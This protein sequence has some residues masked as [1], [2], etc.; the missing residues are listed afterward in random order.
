MCAFMGSGLSGPVFGILVLVAAGV[1]LCLRR[2]A[3]RE[4]R[5]RREGLKCRERL[6][7]EFWGNE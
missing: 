2:H 6:R 1:V 3:L 7:R 5:E 4:A